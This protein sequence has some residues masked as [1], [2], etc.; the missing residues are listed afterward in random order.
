MFKMIYTYLEPFG[1]AL[2]FRKMGLWRHKSNHL[3]VFNE[4]CPKDWTLSSNLWS[5]SMAFSESGSSSFLVSQLEGGLNMLSL[6]SRRLKIQHPHGHHGWSLLSQYVH[7]GHSSKSPGA[8]STCAG[9]W[10]TKKRL[11]YIGEIIERGHRNLMKLNLPT[12]LSNIIQQWLGCKQMWARWGLVWSQYFWIFAIQK[13]IMYHLA[14]LCSGPSTGNFHER[15]RRDGGS[16][17]SEKN[18]GDVQNHQNV[19]TRE[20]KTNPK[21]NIMYNHCV[22]GTFMVL[23]SSCHKMWEK[24]LK[25]PIFILTQ[26][27]GALGCP[28]GH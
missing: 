14:V 17:T 20:V 12:I 28:L 6:A 23:Q 18:M 22:S 11:I 15:I 19:S 2:F 21:G 7:L 3:T 24:H 13:L 5:V 16:Q 1:R 25:L 10:S 26:L 4:L 27:R 9:F 8:I